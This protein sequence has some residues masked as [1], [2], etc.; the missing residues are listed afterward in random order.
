MYPYI[1][2]YKVV[3]LKV[4]VR[5]SNCG[6]RAGYV[7]NL[8]SVFFELAKENYSFAKVLRKLSITN[9][10]GFCCDSVP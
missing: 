5:R 9:H 1:Y 7:G 3:D 4:L 10:H 6:S 2:I 8:A